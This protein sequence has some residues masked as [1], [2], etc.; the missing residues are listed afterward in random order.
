MKAT[1]YEIARLSGANKKTIQRW[2]RSIRTDA[3]EIVG[4]EYPDYESD[5]F[6]KW[7]SNNT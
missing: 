6:G 1:E 7:W 5:I 2:Q 3:R 4:L